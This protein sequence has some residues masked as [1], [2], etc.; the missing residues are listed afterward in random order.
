MKH[1]LLKR[2][3]HYYAITFILVTVLFLFRNTNRLI[4]GL[5]GRYGFLH[6]TLILVI[7]I[8]FVTALH[9]GYKNIHSKRLYP[10]LVALFA[11]LVLPIIGFATYDRANAYYFIYYLALGFFYIFLPHIVLT[12]FGLG[13]GVLIRKRR[14]EKEQGTK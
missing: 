2:A 14:M 10:V 4:V 11:Y 8:S 7:G 5:A 3:W 12:F 6:L 1:F 9:M 13:L